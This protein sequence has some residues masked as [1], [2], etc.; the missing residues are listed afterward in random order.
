MFLF[1]ILKLNQKY[2]HKFKDIEENLKQECIISAN[3]Y[4]ETKD[5]LSL[6][7]KNIFSMYYGENNVILFKKSFFPV[8]IK[9]QRMWVEVLKFL[10]GI[11]IIQNLSLVNKTFYNLSWNN[12]M[13]KSLCIT[14]FSSNLQY[15]CFH[16]LYI[17]LYEESCFSCHSFDTSLKYQRLSHNQRNIC[18]NCKVNFI[19]VGDIKQK[20]RIHPAKFGIKLASARKGVKLCERLR[21]EKAAVVWRKKLKEKE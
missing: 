1:N 6:S 13:F 17:C 5:T 2:P 14:E 3:S 20:F 21:V 11:E 10:P 15:K 18:K 8:K 16:S 7:L 19:D 4:L 9:N 12:E